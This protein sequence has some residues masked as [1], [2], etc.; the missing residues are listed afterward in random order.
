MSNYT[1]TVVDTSGIQ[2]YIFG[3]N[4][5][6]QN[7]GA[8]HLV[9]QAT[10]IWVQEALPGKNNVNNLDNWQQP[11]DLG[12]KIEEGNLDAEVIYAGGGNVLILFRDDDDQHAINFTRC[13]TKRVLLEAPGLQLVVSHCHGFKWTNDG[14]SDD[15]LGGENGWVKQLMDQLAEQKR[16][17]SSVPAALGFGVTAEGV[18][19]DTPMVG[20]DIDYQDANRPAR[21]ISAESMAKSK[22]ED[23]SHKRLR[24]MLHLDELFSYNIEIPRDFEHLGGTRG[25]SSYIAVVHADGNRMGKRIEAIRDNYPSSVDNRDYINHMR[26]F[27]QRMQEESIQ[28][29]RS[30]MKLLAN[31]IREEPD[32]RRSMKKRYRIDQTIELSKKGETPQLPFRPIVFGGDDL[33]FVCDGRLGLSLAVHYLREFSKATLPDVPE[34]QR[35][36]C[37]AGVAVVHSHY[38]FARAYDLAEDL[39]KS[40]KKAIQDWKDKTREDGVTALDWHVA[41]SGLI[42]G[43]EEVRQ[44]EYTSDA[45]RADGDRRS[46]DLLMRPVAID[47]PSAGWR[48]WETVRTMTNEYKFGEAWR[49]RRNKV[50]KLQDVLRQGTTEAVEQFNVAYG[51]L[52]AV[53]GEPNMSKRGWYR[54]QTAYFDTIEAMDY[55]VDLEQP[56]STES[57][58]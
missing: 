46:G 18:F 42:R 16:A 52:P 15:A 8:S 41:T 48:T 5:L 19:T 33:T 29:L 58:N 14:D 34:P 26:R 44:R 28:A 7:A 55:F 4:N 13:L 49:D 31:S 56:A 45:G 53:P 38:P 3:T 50:K 43:L 57:E 20:Y 30:T 11:F 32:P 25:E 23:P 47:D 6:Q 40:A 9:V 54:N 17:Q 22:G 21:P 10:R 37:R 51:D 24:D 2:N 36:H 1:L 39:C 27:S 12:K 35:A